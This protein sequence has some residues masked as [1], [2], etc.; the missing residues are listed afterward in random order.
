MVFDAAREILVRA[1]W[2]AYLNRLQQYNE[3]VAIEFLQN[4][5]ENH[6]MV[7][8]RQ[9]V[10]IY[11]IIA[12][13]SGLPTVGLVWTLKKMRLQDTITI[14]QDEGRTLL[15]KAKESYRQPRESLGE[16]WQEL[17]KATLLAMAKKTW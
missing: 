7:R 13:V 12:E 9:I 15:S 16:N 3:T 11:E 10:V 2:I 6:S 5:P 4:L 1:R 14:F 17:S 8:G